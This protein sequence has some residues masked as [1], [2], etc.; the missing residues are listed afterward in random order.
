MG[1]REEKKEKRKQIWMSI[2]LAFIMVFSVFGVLLGT[3][4]NEMK[5]NG[6]KFQ[7]QD[8]YYVTKINGNEMNFYTL[9][10]EVSYINVSSAV[11]NTLKQADFLTIAFN[12][13]EAQQNLQPIELMRFELA[14]YLGSSRE[15]VFSGVLKASPDYPD[16]PVVSCANATLKSPMIVFN[17]SDTAGIVNLDSCIYLNGRGAD[18]IRMRDRILYSYYGVIDDEKPQPQ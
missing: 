16:L 11:M 5:F 2:I 6:F 9:P 17:V 12:P 10:Y 8:N 3:Q 7:Q 13:N 4:S 18:F 1:R 14:R 15:R